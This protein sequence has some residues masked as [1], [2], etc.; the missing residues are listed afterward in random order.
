MGAFIF[1]ASLIAVIFVA[2]WAQRWW[3]TTEWKRRGRGP[4]HE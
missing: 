1:I 4:E 2:D 3:R